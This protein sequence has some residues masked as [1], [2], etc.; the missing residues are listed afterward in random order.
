MNIYFYWVLF[1]LV[2]LCLVFGTACLIM[3]AEAL[4]DFGCADTDEAISKGVSA[5]VCL[6]LT[7]GAALG[8]YFLFL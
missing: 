5:A 8:L 2:T 1:L 4:G 3:A 7:G 6:T